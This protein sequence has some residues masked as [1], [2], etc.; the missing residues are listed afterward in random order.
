MLLLV[1]YASIA[2]ATHHHSASPRKGSSPQSVVRTSHPSER[3]P[4]SGDPS[5][6][7]SCRLQRVFN[8]S[9][10]SSSIGVD[11]A[12]GVVTFA[13]LRCDR[14][15]LGASIVFSGRAPPRALLIAQPT[16]TARG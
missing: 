3:G 11:A 1:V 13:T 14:C 8:S 2:N 6:C 12:S 10:R 5:H 4:H 7:T 16:K 9:L 15:S